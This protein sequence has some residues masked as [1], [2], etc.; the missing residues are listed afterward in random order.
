MTEKCWRCCFSLVTSDAAT[1]SKFEESLTLIGFDLKPIFSFSSLNLSCVF[2]LLLVS[3]LSLSFPTLPTKSIT[4]W[5]SFLLGLRLYVGSLLTFSNFI[6]ITGTYLFT[7]HSLKVHAFSK[8]ESGLY[9]LWGC[10]CRQLFSTPFSPRLPNLSIPL[11]LS[12]TVTPFIP[13]PVSHRSLF[14][15]LLCRSLPPSLLSI[16]LP[17]RISNL[18][19]NS[20]LL[21]PFSELLIITPLLSPPVLTGTILHSA[22]ALAGLHYC[23]CAAR[24]FPLAHIHTH[25]RS[26]PWMI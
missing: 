12:L 19:I 5:A 25:A 21:L 14:P 16:R 23:V 11:F 4:T 13:P 8:L 20:P 26:L 18:F 15:G 9:R 24:R 17:S 10:R 6:T 7:F 2:Y 22:A 1:S 3:L